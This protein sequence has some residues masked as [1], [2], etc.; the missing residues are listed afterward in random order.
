GIIIAFPVFLQVFTISEPSVGKEIAGI[1]L[2]FI[3]LMMFIAAW[4][5]GWARW[6][7]EHPRRDQAVSQSWAGPAEP[8]IV[9]AVT[10]IGWAVCGSGFALFI[11]FA[12]VLIMN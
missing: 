4:V 3:W 5:Q 7:I 6:S 8:V 1:S 11:V 12:S 10:G 9:L 2:L